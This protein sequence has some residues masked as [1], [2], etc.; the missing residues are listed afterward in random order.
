MKAED[1]QEKIA[2]VVGTITNDVRILTVPKLK[3]CV[4]NL[5]CYVPKEG[6]LFLFMWLRSV[7][8][9]LRSLREQGS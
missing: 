4:D 8:C 6:G 5:C 9:V 2:V 1:R 7:R 3:V